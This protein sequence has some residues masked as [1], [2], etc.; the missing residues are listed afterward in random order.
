MGDIDGQDLADGVKAGV[1]PGFLMVSYRVILI[2]GVL[3][4]NFYW[5]YADVHNDGRYVKLSDYQRDRTEAK[6]EHDRERASDATVEALRES[7][8]ADKM[9]GMEK[10][11]SE[12][13]SDVKELL[14]ENR[15]K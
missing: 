6:E 12:I 1:K 4:M 13:S 2:L 8:T 3:L 5:L 15:N 9:A 14:K 10:W 11:L 7:A